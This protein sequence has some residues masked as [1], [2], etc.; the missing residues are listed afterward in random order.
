MRINGKNDLF[1]DRLRLFA[2][3]IIIPD[4]SSRVE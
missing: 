3:E 4:F 1:F 2:D